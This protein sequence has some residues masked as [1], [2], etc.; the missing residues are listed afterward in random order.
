MVKDMAL[1]LESKS[2]QAGSRPLPLGKNWITRFLTRNPSLAP[3]LT[4]QLERQRAY[5]NHPALLQDYFAKLG[6]L[7]RQNGL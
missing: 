4:T 3:K 2:M 6:R 5:V 7:I 1:H